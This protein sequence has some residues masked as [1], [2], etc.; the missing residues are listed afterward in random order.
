MKF[1]QERPEEPSLVSLRF[2]GNSIWGSHV[3]E[4]ELQP[5][6]RTQPYK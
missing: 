4:L 1:V 2:Q 5:F 6:L 3:L